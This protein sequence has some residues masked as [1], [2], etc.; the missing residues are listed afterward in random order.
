MEEHHKNYIDGRWVDA[1]SGKTFEN[2]NPANQNDLI[3]L[4]PLS[5]AEDVHR[6]VSAAKK[7]FPLWNHMPAPRFDTSIFWPLP[8]RSR[9]RSAVV[10]PWERRTAPPMSQGAPV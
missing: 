8:V 6:A 1:K 4:F 7:A 5:A 9:A 10:M 3:G 2:R